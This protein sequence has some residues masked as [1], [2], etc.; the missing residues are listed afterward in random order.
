MLDKTDFAEVDVEVRC[1]AADRDMGEEECLH[2]VQE[3][4]KNNPLYDMHLC[5]FRRSGVWTDDIYCGRPNV[6]AMLEEI[7][8]FIGNL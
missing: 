5:K 3:D 2:Y 7:D 8:K 1:T 6:I 4:D